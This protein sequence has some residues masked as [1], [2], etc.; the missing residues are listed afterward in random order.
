MPPVS[1]IQTTPAAPSGDPDG[2]ARARVERTHRRLLA[3]ATR[4]DPPALAF[5]CTAEVR[6]HLA[7]A[8][9]TLYPA[10]SAAAETRL[11]V[12]ALRIGRR[13]LDRLIDTLA[14]AGD[15]ASA[16]ATGRALAAALEAHLTVERTLLLPAL[17]ALPGADLPALVDDLQTLL[18]GGRLDA[19]EVVDV[20]GV[21]NG[22]RLPR[23][24]TRFARLAPGDS[25]TLLGDDDATSLR[26]EL[27]TALPGAFD[28]EHLE[29]GPAQWSIR[30]GR[31]ACD[32]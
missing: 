26:E 16:A 3:E 19:P 24:L 1:D 7:C 9:Q 18:H 29:S 10:A 25:F 8:Q 11:L 15:P 13:T 6:R 31:T 5:F 17:A 23:I 32:E 21:P 22:S 2:R 4:L 28:W 12:R 14:A 27:E 30:I 20:R